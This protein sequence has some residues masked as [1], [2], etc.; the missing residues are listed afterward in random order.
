[1]PIADP[2]PACWLSSLARETIQPMFNAALL[3][4]TTVGSSRILF[5]VGIVI[6]SR[7]LTLTATAEDVS[8][9]WTGTFSVA[10]SDHKEPQLV[11]LK[12]DGTKLTGSA[13]PDAVEQYQIRNGRVD[14]NV[15][16]E[17]T[18]GS[19][20]FEYNLRTVGQEMSGDLKLISKE[21]D[22]RPAHVVL[23]RG[24]D[25][26]GIAITQPKPQYAVRAIVDA[27]DR[28]PIIAIGEGHSLREVGDFYV[29]LVKDRGFQAKV[30]DM[31]IEFGSRLSQPVLDRYINGEEV[32]LTE[33]RQVWRNTTKVFAFESPIYA[34]LLKAIRDGNRGL[35]RA[36]RIRVL[37]GDSPIDWTK[38]TTHEQWESYQP[39][40]LSF[41]QIIDEQV[42]ARDRKALVIMGG[43]H[44]AKSTDPTRDPNTTILVERKYPGT[45]YVVLLDQQKQ[46]SGMEWKPPALIPTA[47][48]YVGDYSD[49]LLYLGQHLSWAQPDWQ[50]YRADQVYLKELD[51]RARIEW[52]CGFDLQRFRKQQMP[53]P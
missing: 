13:G 49:A 32:P 6:G 25:S 11:I 20:K 1:M 33:L 53:C 4:R 40:D 38:V 12:Q 10:G 2:W 37:A 15:V 26:A 45:V 18:S 5:F 52:G 51:R 46:D 34:Q 27:F 48:P 9:T 28:F 8:G 47:P 16:F 30:N 39:N 19:W 42:L 29:S 31:V 7:T 22:T 3:R 36:H 17:V 44:V 24:H 35:P 41:A 23:R 21:G 43:S 50:Q 14:H